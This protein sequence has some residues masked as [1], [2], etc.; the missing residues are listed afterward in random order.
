LSALALDF[1]SV[2]CAV[3][4]ESFERIHRSNLAALSVIPLLF[5]GKQ[6]RLPLA[7]DGRET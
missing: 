4:A 7:L 6:S 2:S 5:T 1:A 3:I